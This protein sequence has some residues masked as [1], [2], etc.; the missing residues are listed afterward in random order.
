VIFIF[1]KKFFL[2]Y[3]CNLLFKRKE[4]YEHQ[5]RVIYTETYNQLYILT[6]VYIILNRLV[7]MILN[8]IKIFIKC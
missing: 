7:N 1:L 6:I 2:K 8:L 3:L 5:K 4:V